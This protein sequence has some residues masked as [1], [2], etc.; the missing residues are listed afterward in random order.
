MIKIGAQLFTL[1]DYAENSE[2]RGATLKKVADIGYKY[3]QLSAFGD[4]EAS[5]IKKQCDENGLTIVLTHNSADRIL[6]DTEKLIE[7]HKIMGCTNIGIGS[8]PDEYRNDIESVR[9][10]V[11]DF[12]APAKLMK[13]NG[14]IFQY[15]NHAF[16]FQKDNGKYLFD[17]LVNETDPDLLHFILDTYWVQY[18]GKNPVEIFYDLKGRIDVC[19]FKDMKLISHEQRFAPIGEGNL[20]WDKIIKACEDTGVEYA[21]IEQDNCYGLDPFGE[22]KKSFDFLCK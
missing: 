7:D 10:F 16:E 3:V 18:G 5:D 20:D 15:H 21:M 11:K 1:R 14:M 9:K 4:Y 6:N 22:L 17:V 19:H 2:M 12:E 13:E 8:M